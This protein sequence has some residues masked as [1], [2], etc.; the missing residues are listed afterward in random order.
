MREEKHSN[1]SKNNTLEEQD[2]EDVTGGF[3]IIDTCQNR[4]VPGIC[5]AIL[6]T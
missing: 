4:W 2:L 1:E 5:N 6:L 3:T